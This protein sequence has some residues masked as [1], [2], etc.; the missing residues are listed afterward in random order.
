MDSDAA[1]TAN[2][3]NTPD[4]QHPQTTG[5]GPLT[6]IV[7]AAYI[8]TGYIGFALA[9]PPGNVSILWLPSGIAMAAVLI[10]GYQAVPGI[11]LGA[12]VINIHSFYDGTLDSLTFMTILAIVAIS[13][14]NVLQPLIGR[15]LLSRFGNVLNPFDSGQSILQSSLIFAA[16]CT[17]SA[18]IGA[19]SLSLAA[20]VDGSP[21]ELFGT[22][23]VGDFIGALSFTP[24]L[25]SVVRQSRFV[26]LSLLAVA[27]VTFG[28]TYVIS[29]HVRNQAIEAW[30]NQASREAE[31]LT[32]TLISWLETAS[33][34]VN[35]ISAVLKGSEKIIE[36]EFF[37]A[38][39]QLEDYQP[40]FFPRTLG[41]AAQ[42]F[43]A[44]VTDWE[45][46][47]STDHNGPL[48]PGAIIADGDLG[49]RALIASRAEPG[50]LIIGEFGTLSGESVAISSVALETGGV[51]K[52]VFG[53]LNLNQMFDGLFAVQVPPGFH[54]HVFG[55]ASG[56]NPEN[57]IPI[58]GH[59]HGAEQILDTKSIRGTA[60]NAQFT[61]QWD[62]T[63]SFLPGSREDFA[64]ALLI[65]GILGSAALLLFFSFVLGQ[66][67]QI[68]RRVEERT[69]ELARQTAILESTMEAID[70]GIT[71]FDRDLNLTARN[72]EFNRMFELSLDRFPIGTNLAEMLRHNAENGEYGDGDIE[73]MVHERLVL[74]TKFEP[75]RFE[76]A[77]PNGTVLEIRGNPLPDGSGFVTTYTDITE[78]K[79]SEQA[80]AEK[81]AM[82]RMAL[83]N[84]PGGIAMVDS[85][86]KIQI[87][88]DTYC[89]LY[90]HPRETFAPG[91]P[92]A[93]IIRMNVE[94]GIHK[95]GDHVSADV[96]ETVRRRLITFRSGIQ[97][98]S[99]RELP[100]GRVLN[101][102]H[103]PIDGGGVVLI[104]TDV[105]ERRLAEREKEAKQEQLNDIINNVQ[106]AVVLFDPDK[107]PIIWNDRFPEALAVDP[108]VIED[109]DFSVERLAHILA[110]RGLYGEG[111]VH[112][113]SKSRI[114]ALW[115]GT[116]RTEM[117]FDNIRTFD[118]LSKRTPG[119]RLVVTYTDITERKEIET[120]VARQEAQIRA[121]LES[122]PDAV[123]TINAAGI[124]QTT[125]NATRII[126]GYSQDELIGEDVKILMPHE[127]AK[128]HDG[129]M[130]QYMHTGNARFIG[131]GPRELSGIRKSGEIFPIDVSISETHFEDSHMFVGVVRDIT[132]RKEAERVLAEKEAMLTAALENMTGGLFMIDV[133]MRLRVFNER[134]SEFY[135]FPREILKINAP[136]A[137]VL[138]VR[139]YRGDYG[140]G[141]PEALV[142][143][144]LDGYRNRDVQIVIDYID[145]RIIEVY[146]A[147]MDDGGMVCVFN[148]VTERKQAEEALTQAHTLITESLS[149][150]S[151]IQRSLLP[152][153]TILEEVFKSH[154]MIWEPKD[155]VGG[156]M[157]WLRPAN[158]GVYL[159]V[160]DCTGHGPPGAF[161]TMIC[162]GALD[163][164]LAE[165]DAPDPAQVLSLMN[166]KIKSSLG[167]DGKEGESDD[168]VELGVCHIDSMQKMITFAG[169]RFSLVV[170]EDKNLGEIKGNK[171]SLGYR[172]VPADI[173]FDNHSIE[174]N[175]DMQF[176][177]WSDGLVDQIG[178]PKRR[179][180]GKR[181]LHKI[182][183]D[184]HKMDMSWQKSQIL[185]EFKDYQYDE[186]RRDDITFFGFIPR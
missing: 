59:G 158:Q 54:L 46:V 78:R 89:E 87:V 20:H 164:A 163:Q 16:A 173:Q 14:G 166:R 58:Y 141:D 183:L 110:E 186:A 106:Q 31:R 133:D 53:V 62:I 76:R 105:T 140:E 32:T 160:A 151:R 171:S 117:S 64:N 149:Y 84:M 43:G 6:L 180:F 71:M 10:R 97:G 114:E 15:F 26:A 47:F 57:L 168:G 144:R 121:I 44:N 41:I 7:A 178:G 4:T 56:G 109:T 143:Q 55:A 118:V 77:R 82:L 52:V 65:G 100:N 176:Y 94:A 181:R 5:L 132:E 175:P 179:S 8:A 135:N 86:L 48:S 70:Q 107:K 184:Y 131:K 96:E 93:N 137:D 99:E 102:R 36:Q 170:V 68:R 177:L 138:R 147:P 25:L 35:A 112:E 63:D 156:D 66:N 103:N 123:V 92:M 80:I 122:V 81:E 124:I 83:E 34:P 79:K 73:A 111:D 19:L 134:F 1:L 154:A 74:A 51:E 145:D 113:L 61:F 23:W 161:M 21:Y 13:I 159:I 169:A 29:N 174:Y 22:W 165:M 30:E 3:K 104:A 11:L 101:I 42:T 126:F 146:R 125:N 67:E 28:G 115:S 129:Y 39:T 162:T 24:L 37:D 33:S 50:R 72:A 60:G 17:V 85:D 148:D 40:D 185:R 152:P 90:G 150:A 128:N 172:H 142:A 130:H 75:H 69:A 155:M 182:V 45:V 91:T 98:D 127:H 136:L 157:V 116:N 139:A 2:D 167:Q 108:S 9:I 38:V 120:A 12:A 153:K 27:M 49:R 88:N 95:S 119:G 18:S